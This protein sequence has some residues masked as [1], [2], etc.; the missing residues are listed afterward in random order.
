M[1]VKIKPNLCQV[2]EDYDLYNLKTF[3]AIR[4]NGQA[5]PEAEAPVTAPVNSEMQFMY[6]MCSLKWGMTDAYF[7]GAD[8]NA[9]AA[10]ASCKGLGAAE[11]FLI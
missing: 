4:T 3:D 9:A 11:A 10:P 1:P 8:P 7:K 2:Y 6:R 5:P